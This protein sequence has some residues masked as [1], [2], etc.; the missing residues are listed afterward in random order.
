MADD[1]YTLYVSAGKGWD[2]QTNRFKY[3][4]I[5]YRGSDKIDFSTTHTHYMIWTIIMDDEFVEDPMMTE[6][7]NPEDFPVIE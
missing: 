5:Y 2:E 4:A 1:I 6:M 3:N 7:V